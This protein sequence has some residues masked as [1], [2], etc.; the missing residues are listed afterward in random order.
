MEGRRKSYKIWKGLLLLLLLLS[1][2]L[3]LFFF[4]LI[5]FENHWNLFCVHQ[6]EEFSTGKK[7][8]MQGKNQEKWL[9]PLWKIFLLR[10]G[11]Y[12]LIN[13]KRGNVCSTLIF[14]L[15]ALHE[16]CTNLSTRKSKALALFIVPKF[17]VRESYNPSISQNGGIART[18]TLAEISTLTEVYPEVYPR[19]WICAGVGTIWRCFE[20][21]Y[22]IKVEHFII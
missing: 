22:T 15:F 11:P 8:F 7:H 3:L 19:A 5:T 20:G 16:A 12:T 6:N 9:C 10:L 21:V 18:F 4:L 13:C 14:T 17:V 2:M 1:L